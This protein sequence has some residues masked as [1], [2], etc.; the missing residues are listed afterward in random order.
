MIGY[1]R[2][3]DDYRVYEVMCRRYGCERVK[4]LRRAV[5]RLKAWLIGLAHAQ[6]VGRNLSRGILKDKSVAVGL[7]HIAHGQL[8]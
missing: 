2:V 1:L 4:V 6:R 8:Q 7:L 5:Y 3:I